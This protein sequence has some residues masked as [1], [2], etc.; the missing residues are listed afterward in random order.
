MQRKILLGAA[1]LAALLPLGCGDDGTGS[2]GAGASGSTTTATTTSSMTTTSS[3]TASTTSA[4]SSASTGMAVC[5]PDPNDGPCMACSKATCCDQAAV[6]AEDAECTA[7]MAC[8]A[9]ATNPTECIGTGECDLSDPE[10]AA[11]YDCTSQTCA[12]ECYAG[13]FDCTADPMGAPCIECAK[14][15]C[16]DEAQACF[17]S[18]SC[19]LCITCAQEAADPLDCVSM[20]TCDLGDQATANLFNCVQT[21]CTVCL[22]G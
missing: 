2:G 9:I 19:A 14:A 4:T 3:T 12:D 17:E 1:T 18:S 11:T 21:N 10:T 15:S 6:C 16:C 22:G 13:G 5:P 7:C 20:G 8:V